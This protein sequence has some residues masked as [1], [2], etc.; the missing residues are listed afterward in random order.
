MKSTLIAHRVGHLAKNWQQPPRRGPKP[1]FPQGPNLPG[2]A[3]KGHD[4]LFDNRIDKETDQQRDQRHA[5]AIEICITCP[6][7]DRCKPGPEDEGIWA[8]VLYERKHRRCPCGEP[9]PS[10]ATKQQKYCSSKCRGRKHT[11]YERQCDNCHQH[12]TTVQP[13]QHF[14]HSRCNNKWRHQH[15]RPALT[16]RFPGLPRCQ[17]CSTPINEQAQRMGARNCSKRCRRR[18]SQRGMASAAA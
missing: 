14:C 17:V 18:A 8:G 9:L 1:P 16:K 5:Q 12:F 10:N 13:Q 4:P 11:T 7:F 15:P 2:A 6:I 3:C